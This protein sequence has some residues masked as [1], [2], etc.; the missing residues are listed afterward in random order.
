MK[1]SRFPQPG[2]IAFGID[3]GVLVKLIG[4]PHSERINH[5]GWME[6][7]YVTTVYRFDAS[8]TLVEITVDAPTLEL[9]S[10]LV[11]FS[12][13]SS[14]LQEHDQ[15]AFQA[16]GFLVSPRFCI[17]FD[18]QFPFWVTTF[19]EQSLDIWRAIGGINGEA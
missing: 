18:P 7:D 4:Q 11:P 19:P 3:P 8:S 10:H 1:A 14:Y 12:Y 5:A 2:S 15:S 6:L 9:D 17:A 13:L 16:A